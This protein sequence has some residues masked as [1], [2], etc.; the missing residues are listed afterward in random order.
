MI[1]GKLLFG[2]NRPL[3]TTTITRHADSSKTLPATS[4]PRSG[5][6]MKKRL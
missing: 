1:K 4:Q 5:H 2:N 6:R 3:L